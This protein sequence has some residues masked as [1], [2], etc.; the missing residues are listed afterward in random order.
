[1]W[2]SIKLQPSKPSGKET[3]DDVVAGSEDKTERVTE[4]KTRWKL[5]SHWFYSLLRTKRNQKI[6]NDSYK[7]QKEHWRE[8]KVAK[9]CRTDVGLVGI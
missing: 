1:M 7:K 3:E 8:L 2:V 5:F 6:T 4:Q 9:E